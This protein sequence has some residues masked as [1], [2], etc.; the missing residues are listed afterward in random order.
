V[1]LVTPGQPPLRAF[2]I[3]SD[4][5]LHPSFPCS[6][7]NL[8]QLLQQRLAQTPRAHRLVHLRPRIPRWQLNFLRLVAVLSKS[9]W[10]AAPCPGLSRNRRIIRH[11][12]RTTHRSRHAVSEAQSSCLAEWLP[13]RNVSFAECHHQASVGTSETMFILQTLFVLIVVLQLTTREADTSGTN[14]ADVN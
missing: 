10:R 13:D 5:G 3:F 6:P 14:R 12:G 11:G 2:N 9:L 4:R 7:R 1:K 8:C